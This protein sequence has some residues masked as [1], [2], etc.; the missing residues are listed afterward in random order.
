VQ[1]HEGGAGAGLA[2]TRRA[3]RRGG[4]RGA[5]SP[6]RLARA[7]AALE[8]ARHVRA[9]VARTRAELSTRRWSSAW[10]PAVRLRA[11]ARGADE[12]AEPDRRLRV[13]VLRPAG[14]VVGRTV[15]TAPAVWSSASLRACETHSDR[16]V[17]VASVTGAGARSRACSIT[18]G[19]DV[20]H[21]VERRRV[22]GAAG[23]HRHAERREGDQREEPA[24]AWR[25]C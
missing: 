2:V 9:A 19:E 14:E 8:R 21:R 24:G 4:G 5:A 1:E 25:A 3:R 13:A 12:V 15:R 7:H 6:G 16:R 18:S 17:P 20:Q 11:A 10:I 23:S 22:A